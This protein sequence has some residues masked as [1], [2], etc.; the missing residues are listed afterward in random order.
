MFKFNQKADDYVLRPTA[1]GY[2][3]VVPKPGRTAISNMFSNVGEVKTIVNDVAQLKLLQ[4]GADLTRFVINTT[5]GF[6]GGSA[7]PTKMG[8]LQH[9]EDF[10]QTLGNWGV[11]SGLN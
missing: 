8:L 7:E 2:N 4:A 5:V 3:K 11:P 1:T 6:L 10:G 9:K